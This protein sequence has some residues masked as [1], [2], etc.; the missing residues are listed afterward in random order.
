MQVAVREV[1]SGTRELSMTMVKRLRE[2]FHSPAD[3]QIS[4]RACCGIAIRRA[5]FQLLHLRI[6][7]LIGDKGTV[8]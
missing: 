7:R 1:L 3:L 2:R 5:S 6:H 4:A 8:S